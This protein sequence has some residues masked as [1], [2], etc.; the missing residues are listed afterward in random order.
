MR[1]LIAP[2]LALAIA[3]GS[4]GV[5]RA[6]S[7]DEGQG[8]GPIVSPAPCTG[9]NAWN[10]YFSLPNASARFAGQWYGVVVLGCGTTAT[11]AQ[12]RNILRHYVR[13]GKAM[14]LAAP[15]YISAVQ[16]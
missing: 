7:E 5:A 16:V 14:P 13:Y 15:L 12:Y 2:A 8:H 1:K 4:A 11:N 9:G 6:S 3:F 10:G